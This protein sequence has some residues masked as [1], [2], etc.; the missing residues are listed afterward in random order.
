LKRAT[1][2]REAGG[3]AVPTGKKRIE[4]ASLRTPIG[5]LG[6]YAIAG[7]LCAVA[8][9]GGE[10]RT[11]RALE[12]RFGPVELERVPDPAGALS[13][14]RDYF[15]G[16]LA[17]LDAIEVET[18]GTAFQRRVWEALRR[19]PAGRTL[20][21]SELAEGIGARSAV[22]A[23]GAANGRNPVPVVIPCHR[24]VAADGTLWGYGG[25]LER[26]RWL[27]E[28]EGVMRPN[29]GDPAQRRLGFE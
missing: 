25:G 3:E 14:L 17:A 13:R 18:G 21:Y 4:T 23:V 11:M 16:D 20:A 22:R 7:R 2:G 9:E 12:R 19:I 6:L 15:S 24:V 8:F 27:L 10:D 5:T 26:K 29:P 28:H 1:S